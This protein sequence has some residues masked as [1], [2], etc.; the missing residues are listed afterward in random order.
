MTTTFTLKVVLLVVA[1]STLSCSYQDSA[2]NTMFFSLAKELNQANLTPISTIEMWS[3]LAIKLQREERHLHLMP[4][5]LRRELWKVWFNLANMMR[6]DGQDNASSAIYQQLCYSTTTPSFVIAIPVPKLALPLSGQW[7]ACMNWGATSLRM[8][9]WRAAVTALVLGC[10]NAAVDQDFAIALKA[11]TRVQKQ[12]KHIKSTVIKLT[13]LQAISI[14]YAQRRVEWTMSELDNKANVSGTAK[15]LPTRVRMNFLIPAWD[16]ADSMTRSMSF[17]RAAAA[18]H[19]STI[20]HNVGYQPDITVIADDCAT[21]GNR[22]RIHPARLH[23]RAIRIRYEDECPKKLCDLCIARADVFLMSYEQEF[24]A[25]AADAPKSYQKVLIHTP[26]PAEPTL[27][28]GHVDSTRPIS[29]LLT[30]CIKGTA[31]D[32]KEGAA[33]NG[34]WIYPLRRRLAKI[35]QSGAVTG[36]QFR[37]HPGYS[38]NIPTGWSNQDFNATRTSREL[39]LQEYASRLKASKIVLVTR[40]HRDYALRKYTEAAFAGSL[41]VGDIPTERQELFRRFVVEITANMSDTKIINVLLWWLSHAKDRK[42]RARLGQQLVRHLT[43]SEKIKAVLGGAAL[44]KS[45][46]YGSFTYNQA[47]AAHDLWMKNTKKVSD[48]STEVGKWS[49]FGLYIGWVGHQNIGDDALLDIFAS[50]LRGKENNSPVPPPQMLSKEECTKVKHGGA[51]EPLFVALG[52]GSLYRRNYQELVNQQLVRFPNAL[53]LMFGSGWD[54]YEV[55]FTSTV[56]RILA[57]QQH[58][59]KKQKKNE[60]QFQKLLARAA[61]AA[62]KNNMPN[63]FWKRSWIGG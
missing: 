42:E 38:S 19:P 30:G 43:W 16:E 59:K 15:T 32:T 39:Q 58:G 52:G 55:E 33:N 28:N 27:F 46:Q 54:D 61:A 6:L 34:E 4:P 21:F 53:P 36:A 25:Y 56:A 51:G 48:S 9:Q 50:I 14:R 63:D 62:S 20:V 2:N 12:L 40:S 57:R 26:Q 10:A 3:K 22:S 24:K 1:F 44:F 8:K 37:E 18:K 47:R 31:V 17:L 35:I 13:H 60:E 49:Q 41:L 7:R 23:P 45:G 5:G 11:C 29:V